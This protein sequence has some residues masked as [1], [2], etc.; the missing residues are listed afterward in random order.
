MCLEMGLKAHFLDQRY[1]SAGLVVLKCLVFVK[2]SSSVKR[3]SIVE[4]STRVRRSNRVKKFT[5]VRRSSSDKTSTRLEGL[6]VLKRL[7]V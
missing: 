4:K 5:R 7:L 2:R 6:T 3:S 1:L